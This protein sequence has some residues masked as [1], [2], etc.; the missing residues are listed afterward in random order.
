LPE[1]DR[2]R[3]AELADDLDAITSKGVRR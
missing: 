3:L 2:L 1:D